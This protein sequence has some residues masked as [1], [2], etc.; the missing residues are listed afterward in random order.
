M[1]FSIG[2]TTKSRFP[3]DFVDSTINVLYK[4]KLD[5]FLSCQRVK[6]DLLVC[7]PALGGR[8]KT[9]LHEIDN[10]L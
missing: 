6:A 2:S 1:R 3:G 10:T 9:G 7:V 8:T 4:R 5:S